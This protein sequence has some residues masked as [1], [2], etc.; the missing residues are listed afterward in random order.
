MLDSSLVNSAR[1]PRVALQVVAFWF[2]YLAREQ[3]AGRDDVALLPGSITYLLANSG[4]PPAHPPLLRA[5]GLYS[6]RP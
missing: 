6:I 4:A 1:V 5:S 2:E 3:L